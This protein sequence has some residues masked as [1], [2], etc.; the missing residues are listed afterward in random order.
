MPGQ[1]EGKSA[2]ITGAASGIG[3][4]TALAFAR[5]GAMVA[6]SDIQEGKG[7]EAAEEIRHEGGTAEFFPCDVSQSGQVPGMVLETIKHFG[8]LD[9]ACNCAGVEGSFAFTA[10]STESN[11]DKVIGI[12][13]KGLWLCMKYEIPEMLKQGGGSIV[14]ISSVLGLVGYP[15]LPAYVASK[16][17]VLGLTRC[18]ALEYSKRGI[19]INSI[20]PGIIQTPMVERVIQGD[21]RMLTEFFADEPIGRL[22]KPEEVAA[23]VIWLCSPSASFVTGHP[24]AVDGGWVAQ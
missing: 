23:A 4:A 18:A 11:W 14:N 5:E 12:N 6:M 9:Y 21:P 17:G 19:R 3:R 20:C 8:R 22:G 16:H 7:W 24:L 1:F 13:L 2:I 10:D 15:G